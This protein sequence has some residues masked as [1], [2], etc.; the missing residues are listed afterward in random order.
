MLNELDDAYDAC[1]STTPFAGGRW[2]RA[3][4]RDFVVNALRKAS[5]K[6]PVIQDTL[7]A[8]RMPISGALMVEHPRTTWQ[9]QCA[10]CDNWFVRKE[11]EVDHIVA[12]GDILEDANGYIARMFCEEDGL[13]VLCKPC[14]KLK[15]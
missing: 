9:Y 13:Q 14:H 11:V 2:T 12:V 3:K 8:S 5:V 7:V 6:W 10:S 1:E 4:Y 15:K